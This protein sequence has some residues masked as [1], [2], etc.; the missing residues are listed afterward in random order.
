[1]DLQN[2]LVESLL[3]FLRKHENDSSTSDI[4]GYL[5]GQLEI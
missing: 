5:K 4:D 3:F 1:M 2:M